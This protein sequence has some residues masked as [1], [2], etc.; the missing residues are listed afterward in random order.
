[1]FVFIYNLA[2]YFSAYYCHPGYCSLVI[3]H[4]HFARLVLSLSSLVT[5]LDVTI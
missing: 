4:K 3:G 5:K 2:N 1:V